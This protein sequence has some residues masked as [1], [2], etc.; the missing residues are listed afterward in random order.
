VNDFSEIIKATLLFSAVGVLYIGLGI[1]LLLRRVPP[2]SWYGCRTQTTLSN[3]E[4]WYDVN[5][6]TGRDLIITGI[7]VITSAVAVF[8][9]R[10]SVTPTLAA[11]FLLAVLVFGVAL[12]VVNSVREQ[13]RIA[14]GVVR[15]D[16]SD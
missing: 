8:M 7:A 9:F 14:C 12:V 1:P 11:V 4:I 3:E 15:H 10:A 5:R 16:S 2:N 13:R 6:V